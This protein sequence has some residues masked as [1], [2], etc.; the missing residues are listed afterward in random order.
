M[1]R[2]DFMN[3]LEVNID[4]FSGSFEKL[5]ELVKDK[6]I[7][8]RKVSVSKISDIF[9]KYVSNNKHT[10][11]EIS[12]YLS[13]SSYLTYLKS[14]DILPSS[15]TDK[16]HIKHKNMFYSLI[17]DYELIKETRSIIEKDFG[18]PSK[19]F[20]S[21]KN[22]A[23]FDKKEVKEQ[24]DIYFLDY[25]NLHE[26]LEILKDIYTVEKA[27]EKLKLFNEINILMIKDMSDNNKLKFIV[28]F[29]AALTM[30]VN[31]NFIYEEGKFFNVNEER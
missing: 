2:V 31:G 16:E 29:L 13:L 20:V 7:N 26:K 21:V 4:I 23:R 5:V 22:R 25:I 12:E 28:L 10:I 1:K 9:S 15:K 24:L 3:P 14:K 11:S 30:V 19:K 17:E 8:I 18:K 6:S 27:I